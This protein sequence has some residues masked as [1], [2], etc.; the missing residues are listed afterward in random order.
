MDN[1]KIDIYDATWFNLDPSLVKVIKKL[2]RD[3]KKVKK[4]RL[5]LNCL[6]NRCVTGGAIEYDT[7]KHI[8]TKY[9]IGG[10]TSEDQEESQEAQK[11]LKIKK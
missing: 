2:K 5:H 1:T 3:L 9:N 10:Y 11:S 6:L 4:D 7:I 8:Y